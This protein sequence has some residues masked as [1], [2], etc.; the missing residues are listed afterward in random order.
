MV[1]FLFWFF[2]LFSCVHVT[3]D[4]YR[5]NGHWLRTRVQGGCLE[6]KWQWPFWYSAA[7]PQTNSCIHPTGGIV[8]DCGSANPSDINSFPGSMLLSLHCGDASSWFLVVALHV[9][10]LRWVPIVDGW[11]E[12]PSLGSRSRCD[13]SESEG[14]NKQAPIADSWLLS[15][16]RPL[17]SSVKISL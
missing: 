17:M 2:R 13:S 11:R 10:H 1:R 9:S 6:P 15:H 4:C 12:E 3:A 16:L 14:S 5:D 8:G 7:H